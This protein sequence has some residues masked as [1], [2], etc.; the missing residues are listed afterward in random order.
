MPHQIWS[1]HALDKTRQAWHPRMLWSRQ[2]T[3]GIQ[4]RARRGRKTL[5]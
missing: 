1:C 4:E 5:T 3:H 2:G